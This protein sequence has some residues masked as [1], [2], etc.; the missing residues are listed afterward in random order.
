MPELGNCLTCGEGTP[1]TETITF[2]SFSHE[3]VEP[4]CA[5]C[6]A[7]IR[8][9]DRVSENRRAGRKKQTATLRKKRDEE[10]AKFWEDEKK[11][12]PEQ[13]I[14]V[15]LLNDGKKKPRNAGE[16]GNR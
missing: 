2:S 6:A 8:H 10:H 15:Q 1:A 16:R 14:T 3:D 12:P 5:E 9:L 7:Q 4:Y 13:R 11:R